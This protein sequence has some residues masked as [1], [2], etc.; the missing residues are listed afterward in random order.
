MWVW[1]S[2]LHSTYS[3]GKLHAE[4]V[5]ASGHSDLHP[6]HLADPEDSSQESGPS[7]FPQINFHQK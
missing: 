7:G 2:D 6:W 5:N 4:Q 3:V 1:G